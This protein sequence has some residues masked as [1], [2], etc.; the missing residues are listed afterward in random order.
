MNNDLISRDYVAN[1]ICDLYSDGEN[2]NKK[3]RII[4]EVMDIINNAPI[5]EPRKGE[6][7]PVSERL[8]NNHEYIKN[9]G[10]FNVS[11]GNRV[12]S[13][14]FDIYETEMFGEPTISGFRVDNAVIAWMPLPEPYK[15]GGADCMDEDAKQASIPY[16]YQMPKDY[17]KNKLDYSRPQ[18]GAK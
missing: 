17:I 10:L 1:K 2:A 16:S 12:Y 9:N 5:A 3:D 8:P 11:D 7:I 6:W 14:W 13:E 18:G 15:K 4:N